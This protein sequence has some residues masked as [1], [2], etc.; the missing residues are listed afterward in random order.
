MKPKTVGRINGQKTA[1]SPT[2][3]IGLR[4][5]GIIMTLDGERPVS[6]LSAGDRVITRDSGVALVTS[7]SSRK[8]TAQAIKILAGSLGHT[9]PECDVTI[10]SGQ[11]VLVRDWRAR[12]LFGSRQAMVPAHRLIDGEFITE[13]GE[14]EMTLYT[15]GFDAPHILYVD[16]LEVGSDESTISVEK[17]GAQAA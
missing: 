4:A 9:R 12:A 17:D 1:D 6:E 10:P 16:G 5:E 13:L 14:E 7:V 2:H 15:I 3:I 8:I 11:P